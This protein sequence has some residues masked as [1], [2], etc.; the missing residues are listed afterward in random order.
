MCYI[1]FPRDLALLHLWFF[2]LL[3]CEL[4][5]D[6]GPDSPILLTNAQ[7]DAN[8]LFRTNSSYLESPQTLALSFEGWTL[9]EDYMSGT[10]VIW[11]KGKLQN[12]M[13]LTCTWTPFRI[14]WS[15]HWPLHK[16]VVSVTSWTMHGHLPHVHT[17]PGT[18]DST[19]NRTDKGLHPNGIYLLVGQKQS[20]IRI[21][22]EYIKWW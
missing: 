14:A 9:Q 21:Y 16:V 7:G 11:E 6:F 3:S 20:K 10:K 18:T 19:V 17:V 22:T 15:F 13:S 5:R 2:S 12:G 8:I 1:T 4:L